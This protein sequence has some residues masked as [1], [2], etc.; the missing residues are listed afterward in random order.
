MNIAIE[1]QNSPYLSI[2]LQEFSWVH[3]LML[4]AKLKLVSELDTLLH[5]GIKMFSHNNKGFLLF[6]SSSV[7]ILFKG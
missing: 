6:D 5:Y 2:V 4:A 1:P 7:S 3:L